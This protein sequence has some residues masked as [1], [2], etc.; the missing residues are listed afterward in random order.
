MDKGV[1]RKWLKAGYVDTGRLFPTEAGTPQGGIISP[2]L[3]NLA[4]DGLQ[5][6]LTT[7]FT[8]VRQARAAKVNFV[9]YADD[10]VIT[11]SSKELM[12]ERVKPLVR[13]FLLARG[14]VLSEEKT[15]V[16]IGREWCRARGCQ[17]V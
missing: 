5:S 12:E 1:L 10:F 15:K 3:A 17:Y 16:T 7:L 14:L 6:E 9:R 13:Q 4:L 8:T 11:G 2:V